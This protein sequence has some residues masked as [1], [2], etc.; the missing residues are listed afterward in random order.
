MIR[1]ERIGLTT[2]IMD[3][4]E[5]IIVTETMGIDG[6]ERVVSELTKQW[7]KDGHSVSLILT[8]AGKQEVTYHISEE[9]EV[10]YVDAYNRGGKLARVKEAIA[11]RNIIKQRPNA[12]CVSLMISTSFSLAIAAIGLKNRVILS[13]RNDPHRVPFTKFQRKMRDLSLSLADACVFQTEDAKEYFSKRIQK[14]GV[15]IYN[16]VN[17]ELPERFTGERKKEIVAAGRLNKQKNFPLLMEAFAR[18]HNEFPDYILS[19]YGEGSERDSLEQLARYRGVEDAVKMPGFEKN[20]YQK[21]VDCACYVSS[22]DYEGMSNSMLEALA[23]GI[24][25]VCTD[26][27]IGGARTVIRDAVNGLL[28]PVGDADRMYEAIK[29]II[30]ENA[31]SAALSENAYLLREQLRVERIA[32]QWA[33]LF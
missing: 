14:K 8:R 9:T 17:Q 12:V 2:E 25:T 27:P 31:L 1:K 30:S 13:E 29:R 24:P 11:V 28:V 4:K 23:M 19:I 5:I 22:S 20:L 26:C 16:P 7:I 33:E 10:L 21:M 15:I 6:P 3:K 32:S 18:L